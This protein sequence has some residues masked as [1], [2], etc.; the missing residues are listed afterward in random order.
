MPRSQ[1]AHPFMPN[2]VPAIKQG[3]LKELGIKSV[4]ALYQQIPSDHRL[5]RPLNLPP[6]LSAESELSRHMLSLLVKNTSCEEVLN[7][8]GGGCV[9]NFFL[10]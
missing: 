10:S 2:S 7:F 9:T 6:A 8:L 4:E 3:L 1:R 5:S